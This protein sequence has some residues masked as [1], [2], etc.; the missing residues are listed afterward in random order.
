MV[1][2]NAKKLSA[3]L[4]DDANVPN[5]LQREPEVLNLNFVRASQSIL[6]L[7]SVLC[8]SDHCSGV[9]P[10]LGAILACCCVKM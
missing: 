1:F 2:N 6:E 7:Q 4:P 5:M 3:L 8:S 9:T 10:V